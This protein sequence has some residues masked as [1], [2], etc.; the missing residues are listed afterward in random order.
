MNNQAR[1]VPGCDTETR[2]ELYE[3]VQEILF[4]DMPYFFMY[5]SESMTA[6]LPGTKN[7]NPTPFSRTY[8]TDA[9]VSPAVSQ[10]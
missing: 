4:N 10:P 7:W 2:A 1:V 5:V 9:W 8:S 3:R 6:V